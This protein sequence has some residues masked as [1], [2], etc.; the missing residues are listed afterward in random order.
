MDTQERTAIRDRIALAGESMEIGTDAILDH[1]YMDAL[2]SAIETSVDTLVDPDGR[3]WAEN[4][5][6]VFDT[7]DAW[8]RNSGE[9]LEYWEISQIADVV[10]HEIG[11][12]EELDGDEE[13]LLSLSPA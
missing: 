9:H 10:F 12:A 4:W 1:G 6:L 5:D 8:N 7:L 2:M 13:D 3:S 11:Y